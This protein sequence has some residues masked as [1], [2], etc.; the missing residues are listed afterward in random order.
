RQ[1]ARLV[2]VIVA[3]EAVPLRE[4]EVA[5]PARQ[6]LDVGHDLPGLLLGQVVMR[7]HLG[8][9]DASANGVKDV[10]VARAVDEETGVGGRAPAG[11]AVVYVALRSDLFT[12]CRAGLDRAW[13]S[14]DRILQIDPVVECGRRM[15]AALLLGGQY[16][17]RAQAY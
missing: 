11:T 15:R 6:T 16:E 3:T 17:A 8:P 1:A 9:G 7:F 14:R 4:G 10:S 5:R 2:L 13:I 12:D